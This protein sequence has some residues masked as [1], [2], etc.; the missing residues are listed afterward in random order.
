MI[1]AVFSAAAR[2]TSGSTVVYV[3]LVTVIDECRSISC[4]TFIST[5]AA[6]ARVAAPWRRSCSRIGGRPACAARN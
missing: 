6:S 3:S 1:N 5:P 2:A 4:T